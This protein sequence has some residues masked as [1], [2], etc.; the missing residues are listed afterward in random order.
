MQSRRPLFG[1]KSAHHHINIT[2]V[3]V[4]GII[5]WSLQKFLTLLDTCTVCVCSVYLSFGRLFLSKLFFFPLQFLLKRVFL[6]CCCT[7]FFEPTTRRW[8]FFRPWT[9]VAGIAVTLSKVKQLAERGD[10]IGVRMTIPVSELFLFH[11]RKPDLYHSGFPRH[12][13]LMTV[14][15]Q[16]EIFFLQKPRKFRLWLVQGLLHIPTCHP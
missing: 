5:L 6:G 12:L 10:P 11:F 1:T 3:A 9:V 14:R 15:W 16:T 4:I 7:A 13:L 2:V 8:N